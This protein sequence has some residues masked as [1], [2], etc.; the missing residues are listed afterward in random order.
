MADFP[1]LRQAFVTALDPGGPLTGVFAGELR[2]ALPWLSAEAARQSA[3]DVL[4]RR[5][6]EQAAGAD[7][8]NGWNAPGLPP[9]KIRELVQSLAQPRRDDSGSPAAEALIHIHANLHAQRQLHAAL[10]EKVFCAGGGYERMLAAALTD[11]GIPAPEAAGAAEDFVRVR[12]DRARA[13]TEALAPGGAVEREAVEMAARLRRGGR[14][15]SQAEP[16]HGYLSMCVH[17]VRHLFGADA[18][19]PMSYRQRISAAPIHD[20]MPHR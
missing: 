18:P 19:E 16:E 10:A 9:K 14:E 15:A 5:Q 20:Q 4:A 1:Q 8:W 11:A 6:A 13:V 12:R 7:A 3:A 17:W 2:A